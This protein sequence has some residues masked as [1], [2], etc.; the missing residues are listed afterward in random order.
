MSTK[1]YALHILVGL[2]D[3][4]S[5]GIYNVMYFNSKEAASEYAVNFNNGKDGGYYT[6]FA[7]VSSIKEIELT[8]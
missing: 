4:P 3:G 5:Y 8:A 2:V 7:D 1:I 6:P